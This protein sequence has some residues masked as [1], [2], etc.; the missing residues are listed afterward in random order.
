M[1]ELRATLTRL[2]LWHLKALT[3]ELKGLNA[4]PLDEPELLHTSKAPILL[5][6]SEDLM[7][8]RRANP[9]KLTELSEGGLIDVKAR[10]WRGTKLGDHLAVE[11]LR[12]EEREG[13]QEVAEAL[14]ERL[15]HPWLGE[16]APQGGAERV[17]E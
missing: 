10:R 5:T 17:G 8:A 15:G 4:D 13:L 2:L 6:I 11:P 12:L 14:F 3:E 16:Q 1:A 7:S 9:L